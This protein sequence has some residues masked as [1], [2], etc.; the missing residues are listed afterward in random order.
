MT[1]RVSEEQNDETR[2][3]SRHGSDSMFKHSN[4]HFDS[5]KKGEPTG[6]SPLRDAVRSVKEEVPD[7]RWINEDLSS[8]II[9]RLLNPEWFRGRK[10]TSYE[11]VENFVLSSSLSCTCSRSDLSPTM[12]ISLTPTIPRCPFLP[13]ESRKNLPKKVVGQRAETTARGVEDASNGHGVEE[14]SSAGLERVQGAL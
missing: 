6:S 13:A 5:Q 12:S 11:F 14:R 10:L 8:I 1:K 2:R 7:K 4:L 3:L 9:H